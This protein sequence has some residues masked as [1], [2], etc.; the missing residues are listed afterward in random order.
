MGTTMTY[1]RAITDLVNIYAEVDVLTMEL[2]AAWL[3]KAP[4]RHAQ[5]EM[6][7][8][9]GEERV[10]YLSQV[11]WLDQHAG[12]PT[13]MIP[14]SWTLR[15]REL[16]NGMQW[17]E[18]LASVHL[19]IEGV[20]IA[21][22][23]RAVRDADAGVKAC[24]A[25]SLRDE[26]GH[27]AFAIRQLKRL[28]DDASPKDRAGIRDRIVAAMRAIYQLADTL[29]VTSAHW[30]AVGTSTEEVRKISVRRTTALMSTLGFPAEARAT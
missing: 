1:Q 13:Q 16:V 19:A 12:G 15:L 5:L 11:A 9:I 18:Y 20:G 22:V 2:C 8:Q 26:G 14:E 7:E 28:L 29:P 27:S 21:I 17:P 23:E 6:A 10:H 24:L 3:S 4:D 25:P 30:E